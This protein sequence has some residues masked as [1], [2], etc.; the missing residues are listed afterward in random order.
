MR[1]QLILL[2]ICTFLICMPMIT[3]SQL[4]LMKHRA[5]MP[6]IISQSG[7]NFTG[8][9]AE[10]NESGYNMLGTMSGTY[11]TSFNWSLGTLSGVWAMND[12]NASGDFNGYI[13]HRLFF[14][15]YNVTGGESDWFIGLFRL[16]QTSNEF[17]AI[18]IVFADDNY[19]IRYGIGTY[20]ENP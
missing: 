7:G 1:K 12:G 8:V 10:K 4:N 17:K 5:L 15:E 19:L 2:G 11:T 20:E 13:L 9:F 14:G 6:K 3:G 16:N 18:S